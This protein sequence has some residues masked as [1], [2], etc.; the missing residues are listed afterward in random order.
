M[1][2]LWLLG[3]CQ[4]EPEVLSI[5]GPLR[6]QVFLQTLVEIWGCPPH[7]PCFTEGS[8]EPQSQQFTSLRQGPHILAAMAWSVPL[9]PE[10]TLAKS[11]VGDH[12]TLTLASS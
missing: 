7:E 3:L 12:E 4:L 1:F 9:C 6:G 5:K 2:N 8:P 11:W 10:C